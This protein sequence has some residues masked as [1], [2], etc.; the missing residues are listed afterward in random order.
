MLDTHWSRTTE[1]DGRRKLPPPPLTGTL[2]LRELGNLGPLSF[3]LTKNKF[4]FVV[5]FISHAIYLS[6]L[7]Y[8]TPNNYPTKLMTSS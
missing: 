2:F 3:I 6:L 5:I 4:F 1:P 7:R 8:S